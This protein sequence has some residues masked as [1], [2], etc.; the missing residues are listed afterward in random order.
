MSAADEP[1]YCQKC[2]AV[3]WECGHSMEETGDFC[4][5]GGFNHIEG[6]QYAD[7]WDEDGNCLDC[8]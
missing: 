4:E 8:R 2:D 6:L 7:N 5:I 1:L 3:D